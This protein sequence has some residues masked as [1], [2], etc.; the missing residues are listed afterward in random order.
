MTTNRDFLRAHLYQMILVA[1]DGDLSAIVDTLSGS[2]D[3]AHVQY[4]ATL[5]A[6]PLFSMPVELLDIVATHF[7]RED[8]ARILTVNKVFHGV[9]SRRLWQ[10]LELNDGNVY[11]VTPSA[12]N[13]YGHLVHYLEF[14]A[15]AIKLTE[16][17][18][19]PNVVK[20]HL[21]PFVSG[22]GILNID[23]PNLRDL[24]VMI[25]TCSER[26]SGDIA[27]LCSWIT[28]MHQRGQRLAVNWKIELYDSHHHTQLRSMMD[29]LQ[30][31]D[32]SLHSFE[33]KTVVWR[34]DEAGTV[35]SSLVPRVTSLN[36][37]SVDTVFYMPSRYFFADSN[38][39]YPNLHTIDLGKGY[40]FSDDYNFHNFTPERFPSLKTLSLSESEYKAITAHTH[41]RIFAHTWPSIT[42]LALEDYSCGDT[43]E[44]IIRRTPNL[45]HLSIT[46]ITFPPSLSF[47]AQT[48]LQLKTLEI[49]VRNVPLL[50]MLVLDNASELPVFPNLQEFIVWSSNFN[51]PTLVTKDLILFIVHCLPNM[52]VLKLICFADWNGFLNYMYYDGCLTHL[53]T[54]VISVERN[55]LDIY[56]ITKLVGIAANLRELVLSYGTDEILS[57]LRKTYPLLNV[58]RD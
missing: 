52:Q 44:L 32:L 43:F 35:P 31:C 48:A 55:G 37:S 50:S 23:M 49:I 9:F 20:L 24:I 13:R 19:L 11:V 21:R 54:L 39:N 4:K 36:F 42:S 41:Q 17:V 33:L 14:H 27:R 5:K 1:N 18:S 40:H 26:S 8:C 7:D 57:Q 6:F 34:D 3:F 38:I 45:Q 28:G 12:W 46:D 22:K 53:R 25:E 51:N 15:S 47:L 58:K 10:Q 16:S 30:S 29:Q 56:Q 2:A